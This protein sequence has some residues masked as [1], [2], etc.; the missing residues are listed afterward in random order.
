MNR[1]VAEDRL[2]DEVDEL[3]EAVA[4]RP[5]FAVLATK[6]HTNAV[7][8]QMVGLVRSWSDADGLAGGLRDPEGRRAR[9]HYLE[10]RMR[11]K[12]D[13]DT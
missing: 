3:A 11:G 1:V 13:S 2:D 6:A 10:E 9:E 8:E 12:H 5:R 4:S 7:T